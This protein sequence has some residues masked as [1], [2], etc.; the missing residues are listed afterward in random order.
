MNSATNWLNWAALAYLAIWCW[1]D[2]FDTTAFGLTILVM[3]EAL[4]K[5]FFRSQLAIKLFGKET[6]A[7][8]NEDKKSVTS[9]H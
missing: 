1:I 4:Q 7:I 2:G 6:M 8:V 9:R 3:V 5:P